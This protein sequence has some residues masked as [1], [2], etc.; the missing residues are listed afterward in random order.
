MDLSD[1]G[2]GSM[3]WIILVRQGQVE[4]F[5]EHDNEPSSSKKMLKNS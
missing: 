2:W 1:I 4:A 5:S 3:D